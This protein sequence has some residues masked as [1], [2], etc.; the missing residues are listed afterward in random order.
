MIY[1]LKFFSEIKENRFAIIIR[2]LA[3]IRKRGERMCYIR[4][5]MPHESSYASI[6]RLFVPVSPVWLQVILFRLSRKQ[7]KKTFLSRNHGNHHDFFYLVKV[8]FNPLTPR[9]AFPH[10]K[11]NDGFHFCVET[12]FLRSV[13]SFSY[14]EPTPSAFLKGFKES[15][16]LLIQGWVD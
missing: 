7:W 8:L 16:F 14:M 4:E 11:K 5:P 13:S 6:K 15:G 1:C 3:E 9:M 10:I 2:S 12:C